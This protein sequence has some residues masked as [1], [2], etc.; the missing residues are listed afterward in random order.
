MNKFTK[1]AAGVALTI[2]AAAASAV[3]ITGSIQ[4]DGNTTWRPV[5]A[6]G[7][8]Q[9]S[10]GAATTTGF[11]L[12]ANA[13][14][15]KSNMASSS[16]DFTIVPNG[17]IGSMKDLFNAA[18]GV[19]PAILNFW[20]VGGFSFDLTSATLVAHV[21]GVSGPGFMNVTGSGVVHHVGFDDTIGEFS[22]TG[23]KSG[24]AFSFAA[25]SS[26]AEVPEPMTLAMLG[27]GLLGLGA[28]RRRAKA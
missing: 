13:T 2:A 21:G 25:D 19:P 24:S 28:A 5:D 17:T 1:I 10:I 7:V 27:A 12:L 26:T 18:T 9:P 16:G 8:T 20:S 11:N 23:T 3:P 15:I 22:W 14:A 4:L 6:A